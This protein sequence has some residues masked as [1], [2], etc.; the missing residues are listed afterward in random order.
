MSKPILLSVL[1][2]YRYDDSIFDD[3][4]VP[5]GLDKELIIESI[6]TDCNE[7][8][9]L[10]P[11]P[12]TLKLMIKI[13]SKREL[14]TWQRIYVAANAQ[15]NP[16]E[17]YDRHQQDTRTEAHSGSDITR[18]GRETEA[19]ASAT[20]SNN[21]QSSGTGSRT[22]GENGQLQDTNTHKYAAFD[23]N[24]LNDQ[25]QDVRSATSTNTGT[26]NTTD[27]QTTSET[28][29]QASTNKVDETFDSEVKYGKEVGETFT[30]YIHGNIGVTTS[31]QMLESEL[32]ISPK[33]NTI[34]YIINSFK[35]RFCILVY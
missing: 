29:T 23:A 4:V 32:E 24:T 12:D 20:G 30:S 6:L 35:M 33:L 2:L 7:L 18:E 21:G 17:N 27:A 28:T 3:M 19:Q 1:G 22:T 13:W 9:I 31:Q 14:P 10:Y 34:N 26:E 5:S 16:I 15:Y 25:T 8:E 11:E